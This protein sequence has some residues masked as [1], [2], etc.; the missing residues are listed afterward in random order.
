MAKKNL[1]QLQASDA[2]HHIHPFSDIKE[3]NQKGVRII[4][5]AE[6]IWI[7]DKQ[8]NKVLDGMAGLW[9]VN[10]GYG[11]KELAEVAYKQMQQLPY[12]NLFFQCSHPV[13]IELAEKLDSITP[14]HMHKVFFTS[15]GS[16]AN[17]T[18]IRYVRHYWNALGKPEKRVIISRN[19]A[20]HGSSVGSASLGGMKAMHAQGGLPIPDIVHIEQPYWYEL[21]GEHTPA[22]FG[23]IAAGALEQEILRLGE[24]NVAAFIAEPIQGA[25]GVVIPPVTYWPEIKKIL[26]KYDILFI[27]DE[28]I[29]GFGRIGTW[30]ASEYF[31]LKPDLM[32]I[33]KGLSS[34]YAPMGGVVVSDKVAEVLAEKGGELEHGYT[35][36][37]HPVS[38]AVALENIKLIEANALVDKVS[39][40]TAP[41]L[42]KRWQE[43]IAYELVGEARSCGLLAAIE[44]TNDKVN[45]GHFPENLKVGKQ[46]VALCLENN[47][48]MR[49]VGDTMII[50][51]PLCIEIE[52][53]DI[54]MDKIHLVIQQLSKQLLS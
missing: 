23:K 35:Y 40:E 21:G 6:G 28:V 22:E 14:V 52:E 36:S 5:R 51:P 10:V 38:A 45:R 27:A 11:K 17:D 12:Y 1:V 20:Y 42:A 48:V 50:S 54:L 9:C 15:S 3:L 7:W 49:A 8:G 4:E 47:L 25:G 30:F 24:D 32:T 29:T 16:E 26:A 53:I 19:N 46:G 13:A 31:D 33:A 18:N 41:Y 39:K 44:L 34:G 37:G 2:E 43:L